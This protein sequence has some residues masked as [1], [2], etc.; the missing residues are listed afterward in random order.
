MPRPGAALVVATAILLPPLLLRADGAAWSL[1]AAAPLLGLAGLAGAYP[2]L[3]GQAPRAWSRAALGGIGAAW[4]VLAEPLLDRALLFGPAA[5]TPARA[6]FDGG[7]SLAATEVVGAAATSGAALLAGVWA[8]AALVLPW[9]VRGRSLGADVVGATAWAAGLTAAT[10]ALGEWLGDRVT[11]PEPRGLVFAA[12]LAAVAA[13]GLARG[14][15]GHTLPMQA[16]GTA[17]REGG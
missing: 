7:L 3:A 9:L 10:A 15:S 14:R 2:A 16:G 12:L 13:L 6:S 1:P 8:L 17:Q 5:G 11:T 4:L